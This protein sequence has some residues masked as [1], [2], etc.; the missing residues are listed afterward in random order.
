MC[1]LTPQSIN[2]NIFIYFVNKL[3]GWL[4]ESNQFGNTNVTLILDNCPSYQSS[5][6][7]IKLSKLGYL[8]CFLPQYSPQLALVEMAFSFIKNQLKNQSKYQGLNLSQ[9]ANYNKFRKWLT[10]LDMDTV[11]NLFKEFY[12]QLKLCLYS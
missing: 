2:S 4:E 10:M 8:V 5:K 1:L 7:K 11:R 6:S 12:K 3:K 9:T